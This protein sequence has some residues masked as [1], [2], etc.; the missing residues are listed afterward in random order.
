MPGAEPDRFTERLI[1]G[2][3]PPTGSQNDSLWAFGHEKLRTAYDSLEA[4]SAALTDLR[5]ADPDDPAEA[6][7][8][9]FD[10]AAALEACTVVEFALWKLRR[11]IRG[12]SI[13]VLEDATGQ[14]RR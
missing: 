5:E 4:L 14:G 12:E 13:D 10:K 9:A 8:R 3:S 6:D 2:E 1:M 11:A 7:R